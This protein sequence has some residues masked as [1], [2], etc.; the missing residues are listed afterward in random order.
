MVEN[1]TTKKLKC[2]R[3]NNGGEYCSNEFENYFSYHG[4][5]RQ[6]AVPGT[7]Q[8][9]G[10]SK[11]MNKTTMEHARCWASLLPNFLPKKHYYEPLPSY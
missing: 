10:V 6:K 3:S 9:N 7:P 11:R 8:E 1:E 2:L 4:I 5:H